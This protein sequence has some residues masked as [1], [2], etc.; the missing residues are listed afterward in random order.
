MVRKLQ[1]VANLVFLEYKPLYS[2]F[3]KVSDPPSIPVR[4]VRY[5]LSNRRVPISEEQVKRLYIRKDLEAL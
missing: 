3:L 5:F 1:R 2:S 4:T